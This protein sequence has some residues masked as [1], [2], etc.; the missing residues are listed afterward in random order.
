M[1]YTLD[2]SEATQQELT[3]DILVRSFL[4]PNPVQEVLNINLDTKSI[5]VYNILGQL[6]GSYKENKNIDVS[7]LTKGI[8][9]TG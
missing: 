1:E 2:F 3:Y 5:K 9:I 4:S 7:V 6:V 8:Y